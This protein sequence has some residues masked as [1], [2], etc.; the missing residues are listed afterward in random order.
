MIRGFTCLKFVKPKLPWVKIMITITVYTSLL[1]DGDLVVEAC[2][3]AVE[4][5]RLRYG[6]TVFLEVM[7][8]T[9]LPLHQAE[10]PLVVI[11]GRLVIRACDFNKVEELTETV[12]DKTLE[13]LI[14]KGEAEELPLQGRPRRLLEVEEGAIILD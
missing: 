1:S 14:S 13:S 10:E 6:V 8:S 7:E 9:L 4:L 3:K 2:L 11:D 5:L 12:V